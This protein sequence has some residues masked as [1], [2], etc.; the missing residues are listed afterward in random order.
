M[1]NY[2]NTN[3]GAIWRNQNKQDN[4]NAPDF[5]GTINI[6]GVEYWLSGWSKKQGDNP[7]APSV[8][9]SV[10]PK[11]EVHNQGYQQTQQ[12]LQ[13]PP[14]QQAPQ[15]QAPRQ[16]QQAPQQQQQAPPQSQPEQAFDDLDDSG[17]PF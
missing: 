4:P 15:Q 1:S 13:Q 14:Q 8:K 17:I 3:K 10:Q 16:Q 12:V 11:E 2:D 7:N 5:K 6:E 9:F